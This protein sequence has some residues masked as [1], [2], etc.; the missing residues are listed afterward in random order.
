MTDIELAVDKAVEFN[1]T[2]DEEK[3]TAIT[4]SDYPPAFVFNRESWHVDAGN[5]VL[6]DDPKRNDQLRMLL[7]DALSEIDLKSYP[8]KFQTH[9]M[10]WLSVTAV[11]IGYRIIQ[12]AIDTGLT[13]EMLGERTND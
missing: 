10:K 4:D 12:N 13:P 3:H 11:Q 6:S 9:P 2:I 7:K 8:G 5:Y 1:R